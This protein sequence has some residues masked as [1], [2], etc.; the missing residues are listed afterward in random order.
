MNPGSIV[1]SLVGCVVQL[2]GS[3]DLVGLVERDYRTTVNG[4]VVRAARVR[5]FDETYEPSSTE[6]RF[7][8]VLV[9]EC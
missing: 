9:R 2:S 8:K 6:I 3:H 7:L 5:W 1:R 4:E